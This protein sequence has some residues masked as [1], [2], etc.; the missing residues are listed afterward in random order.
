MLGIKSDFLKPLIAQDPIYTP[1]WCHT[2][3]LSWMRPHYQHSHRKPL[4]PFYIRPIFIWNGIGY[5]ELFKY[6]NISIPEYNWPLNTQLVLGG[7]RGAHTAVIFKIQKL[8][9]TLFQKFFF[10]KFKSTA[11]L[12]VRRSS[13]FLIFLKKLKKNWSL[14][15]LNWKL[16]NLEKRKLRFTSSSD[17][18]FNFNAKTIFVLN[19]F[20]FHFFRNWQ[21]S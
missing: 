17:S 16:E 14:S 19:F 21:L 5:S 10:W 9:E 13:D 8:S 11:R 18:I 15:N 2:M 6:W 20:S 1:V 3:T 12:G 4:R 7:L